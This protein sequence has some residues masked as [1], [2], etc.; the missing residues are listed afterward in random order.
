MMVKQFEYFKARYIITNSTQ[1]NMVNVI[2]GLT[3]VLNLTFVKDIDG[4]VNRPQVLVKK[5]MP[6]TT[7]SITP[8]YK[9]DANIGCG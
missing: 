7:H 9:K 6:T 4:I 1:N 8:T 3:N 5:H 2:V